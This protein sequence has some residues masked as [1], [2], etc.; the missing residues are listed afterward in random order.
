MC[1]PNGSFLS[2]Q[3]L[4]QSLS[5]GLEF[6]SDILHE[7]VPWGIEKTLLFLGDPPGPPCV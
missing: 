4:V 6:G 7:R 2:F 5:I 3:T 1:L